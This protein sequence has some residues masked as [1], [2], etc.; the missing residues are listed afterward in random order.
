LTGGAA[1]SRSVDSPWYANLRKP[2]YQP[3]RQA[4]PVV[5]L[6]LYADI[7]VVNA[8]TLNHLRASAH[9]AQ[10]R[11]FTGALAVT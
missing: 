11:A 1:S 3:P 10:T 4:F 6:L 8:D 2:S 9:S 5:W 7:A